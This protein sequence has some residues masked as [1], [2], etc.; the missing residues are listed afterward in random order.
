MQNLQ[1]LKAPGCTYGIVVAW[2]ETKSSLPL[3][4]VCHVTEIHKLCPSLW[5][6]CP[7][8]SSCTILLTWGWVVEAG[9]LVMWTVLALE[10]R[11]LLA[12][13]CFPPTASV[14]DQCSQLTSATASPLP[15]S[16]Y[17]PHPIFSLDNSKRLLR[18]LTV[19]AFVFWFVDSTRMGT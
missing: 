16:W 5:M 19:T 18:F 2:I 15:L 10:N 1:S 17:L 6:H 8:K 12:S 11:R 13:T 4:V 7:G 3:F 14:P 9:E